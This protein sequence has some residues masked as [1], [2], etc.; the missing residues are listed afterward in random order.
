MH[1]IT[2]STYDYKR[3]ICKIY[4]L[5]DIILSYLYRSTITRNSISNISK[6]CTKIDYEIKMIYQFQLL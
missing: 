6:Q 3:D 1:Q 4:Q 5:V 2:E